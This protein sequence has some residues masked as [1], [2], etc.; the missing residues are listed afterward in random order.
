MIIIMIFIWL[1]LQSKK[2]EHGEVQKHAAGHSA[3]RWSGWNAGRSTAEPHL[4]SVDRRASRL[5]TPQLTWFPF[6]CRGA[7]EEEDTWR[8]A[9]PGGHPLPC[10]RDSVCAAASD[11]REGRPASSVLP[12]EA[13]PRPTAGTELSEE[14]PVSRLLTVL[15]ILSSWSEKDKCPVLN[16]EQ[17]QGPSGHSRT[18]ALN[19]LRKASPCNGVYPKVSLH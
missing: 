5:V 10:V 14:W 17:S 19:S 8:P 1:S 18:A 15:P 16:R 4:L 11:P 6:L 12:P 3:P 7:D 9:L 13:S 2:S